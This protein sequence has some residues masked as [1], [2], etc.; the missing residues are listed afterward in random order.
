MTTDE[1]KKGYKNEKCQK[2]KKN[3]VSY[4]FVL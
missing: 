1:E 4:D 2:R 3:N